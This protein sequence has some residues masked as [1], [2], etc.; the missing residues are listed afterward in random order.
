MFGCLMYRIEPDWGS[1]N[2]DQKPFYG[3]G[4]YF[5][6]LSRIILLI[7]IEL[8]YILRYVQR[9]GRET[10]PWSMRQMGIYQKFD[11]SKKS[12]NWIFLQPS[13][14]AKKLA[15]HRPH[16][17][18]SHP[19]EAHIEILSSTLDAWRWYLNGLDHTT[20]SLVC[21]KTT[22]KQGEKVLMLS[23]SLQSQIARLTGSTNQA[24]ES[25][26][27]EI[28]FGNLQRLQY[29]Q[30][31]L[32]DSLTVLRVNIEVL[33]GLQTLEKSSSFQEYYVKDKAHRAIST[34]LQMCLSCFRYHQNMAEDSLSRT[35]RVSLLV[36]RI[37]VSPR[38][39][40]SDL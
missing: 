19:L 24:P 25:I 22:L 29:V 38:L 27:F 4:P 8:C 11:F 21:T 35:R 1:G 9:T 28:A 40:L 26:D 23:Y 14:Q 16:V 36:R 6:I 5:I 17:Q 33:N 12:S 15:M 32:Q 34:K 37:S 18:A 13:S 7:G 10:H 3:D 31:C 2:T 39:L 30:D 20:R